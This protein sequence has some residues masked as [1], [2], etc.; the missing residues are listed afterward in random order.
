MS[1]QCSKCPKKARSRQALFAHTI[2]AHIPQCHF[3]DII[4]TNFPDLDNHIGYLHFLQVISRDDP[5]L[6]YEERGQG[7]ARVPEELNYLPDL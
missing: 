3:C 1:F 7:H 2:R 5:S 6:N 4:F